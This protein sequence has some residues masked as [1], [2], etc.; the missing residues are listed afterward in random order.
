MLSHVAPPGLKA[1]LSAV[2]FSLFQSVFNPPSPPCHGGRAALS[3]FYK[4][5]APPGL[6]TGFPAPP[7]N[8]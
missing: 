3:L 7:P 2:P 8:P 6:K 4:H 1:H 5:V